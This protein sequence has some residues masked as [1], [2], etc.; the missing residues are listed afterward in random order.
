M[1]ADGRRC[2]TGGVG[3]NSPFLASLCLSAR[4]LEVRDDLEEVFLPV[5]SG[6]FFRHFSS[7]NC[8]QFGYAGL[9]EF[10]PEEGVEEFVEAESGPGDRLEGGGD[11]AQG[12][13][14]GGGLKEMMGLESAGAYQSGEL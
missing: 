5:C 6:R 8:H 13:G 14:E 9:G 1:N 11:F 10:L 7:P 4:R 2:R 12:L 3:L